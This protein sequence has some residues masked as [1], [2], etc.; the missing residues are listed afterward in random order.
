MLT[1][2]WITITLR[3]LDNVKEDFIFQ[4]NTLL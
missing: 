2:I 4:N 1:D 3:R